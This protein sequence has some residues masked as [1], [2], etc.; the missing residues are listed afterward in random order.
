MISLV[1]LLAMASLTQAN[2]IL[3]LADLD[4]TLKNEQLFSALYN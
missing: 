2:T 1:V 4:N 3:N